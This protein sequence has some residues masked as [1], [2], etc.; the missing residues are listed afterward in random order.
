MCGIF[1]AWNLDDASNVVYLGLYALQHRGQESVG[2]VSSDAK[3]LFTR[4]QRGL[5]ADVFQN[6]ETLKALEGRRAIGHVRYS[7]AGG[8]TSFNV[9]PIDVRFNGTEVA[10]AH[11][12][13]LVNTPSLR[14][15]LTREGAIFQSTMDTEL[16]VH[17]M[18]R[19]K[20]KTVQE[21]FM[22]A[23]GEVRGA[24]SLLLMTRDQLILARDPHGYRPL[25]IGEYRG[26]IV[27]ASES[28]AFDL[29][30]ANYLRDVLP[31][32]VV[33]IDAD[34][35]MTSTMLPEKP[36]RIS[37][38][39]F[40]QVYFARPDSIVF[41]ESTYAARKAMGRQ[42][43]QE[44]PAKG[45]DYVVPVPDSGIPAALGYAEASGVPFDLGLIRNH[46]VHR[47]F[48]EP[49]QS[50]RNFGVRVK[51]NPQREILRG[52]SLVVIDDSIVRGTTSRKIVSMLREA[53]AREVHMRISSPPITS[54]CYFGIDTPTKQ[55][56]IGS[57]KSVEEIRQFLNVD[58]L[59]Y[60]SLDGMLKVVKQGKGNYCVGCFTGNYPEA[61]EPGLM[62]PTC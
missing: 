56:L 54:P 44:S 45:V 33:T 30:G 51:L 32:E 43:A 49:D 55:E 20:R 4:K 1:A 16:I 37:Q 40:E 15:R 57:K 25:I 29:I 5:V 60:L 12:G 22:E 13:N 14:E 42:L 24:Y 2:I 48:I 36:A 31:G 21:K 23:L 28:C 61:V 18:A 38:C 41:G 26:G 9:Q 50:I 58:S 53:G 59:A 7:T 52:K 39:I 17:L 6:P 8:S 62:A 3:R 10:V 19:S 34:G 35:K 27:A 47:T 46:Y 11:N